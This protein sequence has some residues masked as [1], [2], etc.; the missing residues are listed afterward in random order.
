ML[1][2]TV[3]RDGVD[4]RIA[5][6]VQR[7]TAL[8]DANRYF[9]LQPTMGPVNNRVQMAD[10][11]EMIMLASYSYLGLIGHPRIDRAAIDAVESYGTGAG[12]VRLLLSLIHI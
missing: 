3:V 1:D 11:R 6:F 5:E 8:K 10:G 4:A 9:Y 2:A 7:R 12:G